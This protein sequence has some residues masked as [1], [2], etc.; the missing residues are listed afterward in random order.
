M[1]IFTASDSD[2]HNT[3]CECTKDVSRF[4]ANTTGEDCNRS[5]GKVLILATVHD[6]FPVPKKKRMYWVSFPD[7]ETTLAFRREVCLNNPTD[8]PISCEYL[9][10]DSV[11]IIDGSGRITT[12]MIKYL[13]TGDIM[14][15]L[16]HIKKG[17]ESLPFSWAPTICDK[18]LY[19]FNDFVPKAIATKF[20]SAGKDFDH[21][22]I[23]AVG[24]FGDGTMDRFLDRMDKFVKKHNDRILSDE[25]NKSGKIVSVVEAD[26]SSEMTALNAFRFVAATAFKTYC[27]GEDIQGVSVDYALPKNGGLAPQLRSSAVKPLK[28]MRYSHFGCNV[29]HEDIAYA[30]G[31]DTHEEKMAFKH[32][33][34]EDGGKL[35][36]EHGHGTEYHAPKSAQQRWMNMDPFNI[37]NPGVGGLSTLPK[38]GM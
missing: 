15:F 24:E 12:H 26:S 17:I 32:V 6:T 3:V 18:M 13:G 5:E 10:R 8:L 28:R 37:M 20:L 19:W 34:E 38:Y 29:V 11:D 21:H 14:G 1:F 9:D 31:V 23:V 4:N 35:P 22:C 30:L 2:Y 25:K 27:I 16:W 7:M 33:V 36:A